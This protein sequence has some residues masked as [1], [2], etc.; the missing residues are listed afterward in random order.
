MTNN[1]KKKMKKLGKRPNKE[2]VGI[3]HRGVSLNVYETKEGWKYSLRTRLQ[4]DGIRYELGYFP[5]SEER[6]A[7]KAYNKCAKSILTYRVAK[8]LGMWNV[9]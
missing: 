5:A 7:A 2:S 1:T 3:T 8:K 4:K 9:L 6:Q